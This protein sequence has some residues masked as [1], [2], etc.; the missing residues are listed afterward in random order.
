MVAGDLK[1]C[2]KSLLK[3][4]FTQRRPRGPGRDRVLLTF[5]DGPRLDITPRVLD[6]LDEYGARAV[7]FVVGERIAT[8]PTLLPE[9]VRRGHV[10]GNHSYLHKIGLG[11]RDRIA[12]MR[13]CGSQVKRLTGYRPSLYRPP[14]GKLDRATLIAALRDRMKVMLWSTDTEDWHFRDN[15][16]ARATGV[17]VGRRLAALPRISEIVLCHD[18]NPYTPVMLAELLAVLRARGCTLSPSSK[19]DI[20][21]SH[22]LS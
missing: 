4:V 21:K 18:D 13:C 15:E 1:S 19:V 12:D 16:T 2:G 10:L 11:Y 6:L 7:F 14:Q 5:D 8:A 9:I 3:S 17:K 22:P 20:E